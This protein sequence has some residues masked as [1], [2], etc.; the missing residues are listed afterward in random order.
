MV[1]LILFRKT[2]TNKIELTATIYVITVLVNSKLERCA[3]TVFGICVL[4][5]NRHSLFCFYFTQL[6]F[7]LAILF[8]TYYAQ[9]F[10]QSFNILLK[11]KLY[12][13]LLNS[14]IIHII[15]LNCIYTSWT[16]IARL[17]MSQLYSCIVLV[18]AN[19]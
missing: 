3:Y 7:F 8:L 4:P 17:I 16:A 9:D 5:R 1:A 11:V 19:F 14:D 10:A 18:K 12:S 13:Q 6:L 15:Y 2:L